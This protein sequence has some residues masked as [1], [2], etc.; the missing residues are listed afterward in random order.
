[1]VRRQRRGVRQPRVIIL[2]PPSG[3]TGGG[4]FMSG[5][6]TTGHTRE[7]LYSGKF[8]TPQRETRS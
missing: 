2:K 3:S 5:D 6:L 8:I 4:F 7:T 1:M